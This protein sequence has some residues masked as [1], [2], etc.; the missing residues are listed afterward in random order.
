MNYSA[1][2]ITS[3]EMIQD[4]LIDIQSV[5]E[6]E[7]NADNIDAVILRATKLE[8][9]MALSGKLL[10]DAKW[11]YSNTFQSGFME[12][13]KTTSK[14]SASTINLYLK[15]L[16]KDYQ[17]LVDWIDRINATCTHQIDLIR[18]LISKHKEELKL[19]GWQK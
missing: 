5:I 13:L 2:N 1:K 17:Y 15:A 3:P 16:C 14:Y 7:Y 4:N 8:G 11:H 19:S 9:Y 6:A 12:A 10:A 18:S